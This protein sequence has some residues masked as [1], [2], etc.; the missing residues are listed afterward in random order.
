MSISL[1]HLGRIVVAGRDAVNF[2]QR[3]LSCSVPAIGA[4]AYGCWCHP[5][6]RIIS[7]L[8]VIHE[9][10]HRLHLIMHTSQIEPVRH[11]FSRYIMRD[12]VELQLA[13]GA[14]M[15]AGCSNNDQEPTPCYPLPWD[16]QRALFI[17]REPP[18]GHSATSLSQWQQADIEAGIPW[19][20]HDLAERFL[21]QMLHLDR[22]G[23]VNFAKG[24]Y[25]GQEVIARAHYLGQVKR[26]PIRF[27][28]NETRWD[29]SPGKTIY[30]NNSEEAGV[31]VAVSRHDEHVMGLGVIHQAMLDRALFVTSSGRPAPLKHEEFA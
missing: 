2:L 5:R 16:G 1:S 30:N 24:C 9:Q 21:P 14:V 31:I 26:R 27:T 20:P 17:P 23:A 28:M 10:E 6:G 8:L 22:R 29:I 11:G 25:P 3:L 18:R 15:I 7:D 12:L 13:T 4:S 19:L